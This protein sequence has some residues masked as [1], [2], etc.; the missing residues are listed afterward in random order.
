ML[1]PGS[2]DP[3][4]SHHE[5]EYGTEALKELK[6][7]LLRSWTKRTIVMAVNEEAEDLKQVR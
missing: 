2:H 7:L 3:S 1:H 4:L 6:W 5:G